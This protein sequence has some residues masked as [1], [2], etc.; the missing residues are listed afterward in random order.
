MVALAAVVW[1]MFSSASVC[2]SCESWLTNVAGSDGASGSWLRICATSSL[3]N[4][5]LLALTGLA[6]G[7]TAL[8]FALP[9]ALP[10]RPKAF[11]VVVTMISSLPCGSA[12]AAS[13]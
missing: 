10:F 12:T 2:D 5:S 6:A 1:V 4:M 11:E 3:V 13:T 9:F 7:A 8:L